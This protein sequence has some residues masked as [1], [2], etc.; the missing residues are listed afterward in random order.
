MGR[1]TLL[2]I[3]L[4]FCQSSP[5]PA[6][7]SCIVSNQ[8][9]SLS[10]ILFTEQTSISMLWICWSKPHN[11]LLEIIIYSNCS[12]PNLLS[13]AEHKRRYLEERFN[14]VYP[15]NE[16]ELQWDN[17]GHHWLSLGK[18]FSTEES[19]P[20]EDFITSTLSEYLR[21]DWFDTTGCK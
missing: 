4:C 11:E 17:K 5:T 19:H 6:L 14:Y 15:Y 3:V 9:F 1:R 13:T 2:R 21:T 18:N 8:A 12:K 20:G 16:S 7:F 10:M